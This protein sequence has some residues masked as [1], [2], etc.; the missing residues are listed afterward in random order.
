VLAEGVENILKV[1]GLTFGGRLPWG[2]ELSLNQSSRADSGQGDQA[3]CYLLDLE[4]RGFGASR[5]WGCGNW[6]GAAFKGVLR[7]PPAGHRNSPAID[8]ELSE[9]LIE[10]KLRGHVSLDSLKTISSAHFWPHL[11]EENCDALDCQLKTDS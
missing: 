9:I 7:R 3:S 10:I 1:P 6:Q 8:L 2:L 11:R 4:W 5:I